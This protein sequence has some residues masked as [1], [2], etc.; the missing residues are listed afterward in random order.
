MERASRVFIVLI[1][2]ILGSHSSLACTDFRLTAADGTVMIARSMEFAEDLHSNVRSSNRG[3]SF[4]TTTPAGKQGLG[5]TSKYGYIFLDGFNV[6]AAIDGMNEKGL[7]YEALYLPALAQ[8]QS[9]PEGHEKEALSYLK[10][11]DW[12]L[13]NFATVDE[14][15]AAIKTVYVFEE[16]LKQK[17]NFVFP[18]HFSVYDAS[19]KGVIIEY[20]DG[21]LHLYD[22]ALGVLTNSPGYDWQMANLN[23]YIHLN[24]LDPDSV[25]YNNITLGPVGHGFGMVG[26]PGDVTPPS[27]FVKIATLLRVSQQPKDALSS[28]NVAQHIINT[29]DIPLG[30][31]QIASPQG[32][33]MET[34]QWT[35]F[36]DLTHKTLYYRTYE[37]PQIYALSFDKINFTQN[38]PRLSMP[39]TSVMEVQNK[40]DQFRSKPDN[41]F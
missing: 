6:D 31:L 20:I 5:W 18:L 16:P 13:G 37:N 2:F 25:H 10:L 11:G 28:V 14:V 32:T 34:A 24:P 39:V 29:V 35:L 15:K 38:A 36:K 26:L 8:Y 33:L 27:R 22:N 17:A 4:A 3:R 1:L 9:I 21:Q 12:I 19:G 7:S 23:N 40:T 30:M 41:K